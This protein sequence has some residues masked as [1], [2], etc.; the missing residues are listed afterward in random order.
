MSKLDIAEYR[1]HTSQATDTYTDKTGDSFSY[2]LYMRDN[3]RA[4]ARGLSG[5]Y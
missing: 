5:M 1:I 4:L 2:R 3:T